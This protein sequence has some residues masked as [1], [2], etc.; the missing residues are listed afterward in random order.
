MPITTLIRKFGFKWKSGGGTTAGNNGTCIAHCQLK[1]TL[2]NPLCFET[3]ITKTGGTAG[4]GRKR[5]RH[6]I[7]NRSSVV[8]VRVLKKGTSA[9]GVSPMVL[10][11]HFKVWR[12][13]VHRCP[14][15][16]MY[17]LTFCP[18]PP[19]NCLRLITFIID[20]AWC[21]SSPFVAN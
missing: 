1:G 6:I 8:Q 13:L 20:L 16:N 21:L 19:H 11:E 15:E 7:G 18:L 12:V 10:H 9:P 14:G 17:P 4:S 3:C 2:R 5:Y